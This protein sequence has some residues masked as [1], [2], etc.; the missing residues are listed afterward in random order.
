I[1]SVSVVEHNIR[2]IV[3]EPVFRTS[4]EFNPTRCSY[5]CGSLKA[6]KKELQAIPKLNR[7]ATLSHPEV[8]KRL[9]YYR[10]FTQRSIDAELLFITYWHGQNTMLKEFMSCLSTIP[11]GER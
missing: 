6:P 7:A 11:T 9:R 1:M 5:N 3:D 4:P 8:T 10:T 2:I